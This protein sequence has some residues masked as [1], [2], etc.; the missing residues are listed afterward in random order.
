MPGGLIS[1]AG[2]LLCSWQRIAGYSVCMEARQMFYPA[3][4]KAAS[5][6]NIILDL[7]H[8]EGAAVFAVYRYRW[9]CSWRSLT[10]ILYCSTKFVGSLIANEW[11]HSIHQRAY[12]TYHA[13]PV[14]ECSTFAHPAVI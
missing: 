7:W 1:I 14:R 2:A 4:D 6:A 8:T 11:C 12:M 13:S 9:L 10:S 3:I 5:I